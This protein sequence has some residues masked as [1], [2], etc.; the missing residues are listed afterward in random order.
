MQWMNEWM[1]WRN[2]Q[3]RQ[4]GSLQTVIKGWII[5]LPT[6]HLIKIKWTN[7]LSSRFTKNPIS[8]SAWIRGRSNKTQSPGWAGSRT[9][10][11]SP[12]SPTSL[13]HS[14][15]LATCPEGI[16]VSDSRIMSSTIAAH[17]WALTTCHSS[18]INIAGH[19]L[20]VKCPSIP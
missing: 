8:L 12:Q 13:L 6:E 16:W 3:R 2:D 7:I 11:I 14:R 5:F 15:M 18:R 9:S 1:E 19:L 17:F 10:A 4:N 20:S